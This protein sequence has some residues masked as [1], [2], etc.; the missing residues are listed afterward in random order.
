MQLEDG[1]MQPTNF[2]VAT[3]L[4][5]FVVILL[6]AAPQNRGTDELRSDSGLLSQAGLEVDPQSDSESNTDSEATDT[7]ASQRYPIQ[8][9]RPSGP[10]TVTLATG[11]PQAAAARIACSTCHSTR[12]PNYD[13]KDHTSLDEFHQGIRVDHHKVACYACHHPK[14]A[15]SLRSA[16]GRPIAYADV[17]TLCSQCHGSQATAFAHG[18]HGGMV[19][20]WDLSR[21]PQM[22]NNCIDCH[23]PHAP[24]FPKMIVE[25]KPRDRFLEGEAAHDDHE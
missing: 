20:F 16:D 5:L 3:V 18:A 23:D 8:V 25:F 13:N 2:L 24:Q 22:K 10:P 7:A 17:M 21:G 9:R 6:V 4:G 1:L 12:E 15:D 11:D 14:D 19:G